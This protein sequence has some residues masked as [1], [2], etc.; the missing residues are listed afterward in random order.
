MT[1]SHR[2]PRPL[3]AAGEDE[4]TLRERFDA[5]QTAV[6][7]RLDEPLARLR[8]HDVTAQTRR[9]A[10]K[11]ADDAV[12]ALAPLPSGAVRDALTRF[13]EVVVDRAS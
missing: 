1:E 10:E 3:P 7:E 13:A 2:D 5:A 11:W 8:D 12:A 4:R 6:R 9:L